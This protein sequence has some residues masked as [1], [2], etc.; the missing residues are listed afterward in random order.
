[1]SATL[2]D[3]QNNNLATGVRRWGGGMMSFEKLGSIKGEMACKPV[4]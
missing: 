4:N 2:L 3:K 1:M